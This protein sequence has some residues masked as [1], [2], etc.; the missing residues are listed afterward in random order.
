[1]HQTR[2]TL[3]RRTSLAGALAAL[4]ILGGAAAAELTIDLDPEALGALKEQAAGY[5]APLLRDAILRSRQ[6]ALVA[7][8]QPIPP[9]IRARLRGYYRDELLDRVRWRAGGGT[10]VS[11]QLNVIQY[12]DRAAITLNEV[13][14]FAREADA[15]GDAALWAHELWH[16]HQFASWGVDDFAARYVRD[17]RTVEAEAD[18]AAAG[19]LAWLTRRPAHSRA[20]DSSGMIDGS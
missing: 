4:L 13:V 17:F 3:L 5:A 9:A 19:Y 7:G 2:P 20:A 16:V 12:G 8:T 10:E 1:M 15:R 6:E 14:V 18:K 11:L